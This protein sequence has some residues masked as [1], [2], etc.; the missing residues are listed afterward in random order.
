[1]NKWIPGMT[2]VVLYIRRAIK[3]FLKHEPYAGDHLIRSNNE[4]YAED[5]NHTPSLE[6][7]S[8]MFNA[9]SRNASYWAFV[10]GLANSHYNI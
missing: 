8:H 6:V 3:I 5:Q 4:N 2:C 9:F 10:M 1:M 7:K